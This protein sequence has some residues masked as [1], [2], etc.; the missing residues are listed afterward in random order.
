TRTDTP[1]PTPS[2][3]NTP[4]CGDGMLSPP[5]QCDDGNTMSG[6]I[7]P[8]TC[9]YSGSLIRGKR[10]S[11]PKDKVGCQV[12]W[13]VVNPNNAL[14][15]YQLPNR[16]QTCEDQDATCDTDNSPGHCGFQVIV[17]LNNV[18]PNLPSC[19]PNGISSLEVLPPRTRLR[20]TGAQTIADND[21]ALLMNAVTHLLDPQ[22]PGAGYTN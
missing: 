10:G 8:A 13:Y 22:N 7:C 5:E 6:D 9:S 4:F 18:D 1:T 11:P 15:R 16:V 19:D 21:N 2:P 14:D 20:T 12:E 17:C 3:T